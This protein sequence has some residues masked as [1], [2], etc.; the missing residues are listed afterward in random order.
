MSWTIQKCQDPTSCIL[1]GMFGLHKVGWSTW[2]NLMWCVTLQF[3]L[4]FNDQ[5]SFTS[6]RTSET[7]WVSWLGS[8]LM[9]KISHWQTFLIEP[10]DSLQNP[11]GRLWV[12]LYIILCRKPKKNV[13]ICGHSGWPWDSPASSRLWGVEILRR[14]PVEELVAERFMALWR[15]EELRHLFEGRRMSRKRLTQRV[16]LGDDEPT[17][18]GGIAYAKFVEYVV[19]M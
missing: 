6:S 11:F 15:Y 8:L 2:V 7:L 4:C 12:F 19:D 17:E 9:F 18:V 16:C 5:V 14:Q 13:W 3:L 1:R 10:F